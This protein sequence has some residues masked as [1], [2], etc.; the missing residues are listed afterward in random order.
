MPTTIEKKQPG[1]R[2]YIIDADGQILGR[3]A[4]RVATV[5]LGKGKA[6]FAPYLDAGDHVIVVNCKNIRL[7]GQKLKKKFYYRHSQFP[8]GL[9]EIQAEQMFR[10]RPDRMVSLAI[11]GMLPKTKL[12]KAMAKKLRVY[13]DSA[14]PHAAQMPVPLTLETRRA[15]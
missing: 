4:S 3:L 10:E 14:H 6:R 9:K 1:E 7:T 2:W 8:G 13:S 11:R 5:L 15:G 12:G